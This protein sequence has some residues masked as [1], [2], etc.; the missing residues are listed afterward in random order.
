LFQGVSPAH[1]AP[2][3]QEPA[4]DNVPLVV[5]LCVRYIEKL[6]EFDLVFIHPFPVRVAPGKR[7]ASRAV[8]P[9]REPGRYCSTRHNMHSMTLKKQGLQSVSGKCLADIARHVIGC[10][11]LK[12]RR[13]DEGSKRVSM[14][15][16]AGA[17]QILLTTF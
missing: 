6:E 16:R 10:H 2:P 8:A 11:K 15:W 3:Y 12:K 13:F 9:L 7:H 14:T 4:R 1:P 17:W 5:D